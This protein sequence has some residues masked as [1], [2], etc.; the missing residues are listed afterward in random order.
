MNTDRKGN[1]DPIVEH[2]IKGDKAI[3]KHVFLLFN[4][5]PLPWNKDE[6]ILKLDDDVHTTT[7][8]L[9]VQNFQN[10]ELLKLQVCPL[11][12]INGKI[13]F[14]EKI[15]FNLPNLTFYGKSASKS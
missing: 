12:I 3:L 7:A 5:N 11:N 14:N 2:C 4:L 15:Y 8:W 6:E 10:P 13:Y 1:C 9:K